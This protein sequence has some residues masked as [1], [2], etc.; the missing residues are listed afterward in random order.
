[1]A[2]T[3]IAHL[4]RGL[5]HITVA[6]P[7]EFRGAFHPQFAGILWDG[8]PG[9][10]R[11]R[12]AEVKGTASDFASDLREVGWF[13]KM[14]TQDG[15]HAT[16]AFARQPFLSITEQ[17]RFRGKFEEKLRHEFEDAGLVPQR[18]GRLR[19]RRMRPLM[20]TLDLLRRQWVHPAQG[21]ANGFAHEDFLD[22]RMKRAIAVG[23][24][25]LQKRW[26]KTDGEEAMALPWTALV[27][28]GASA[29]QIESA[30]RRLQFLLAAGAF[31]PAATRQIK[32]D[33]KDATS[34][35][36]L[37]SDVCCFGLEPLGMEGRTV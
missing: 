34:D 3:R 30:S 17:F 5:R 15:N 4:Q 6:I 13:R 33:F 7:E 35:R 29:A 24:V 31:N 19:G 9:F 8:H 32:T 22:Q 36:K 20:S 11:E 16:D 14:T 10:T 37:T 26:R 1:M 21:R 25:T 18:T 28:N 23:E 2:Q 12:A 27:L